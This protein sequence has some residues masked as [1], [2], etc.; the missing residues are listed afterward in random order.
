MRNILSTLLMLMMVLTEASAQDSRTYNQ[1]DENG[2]ITQRNENRNFNKNSNDTTKN[3]EVPKG[4]FAWKVDRRFGD[5]IPS[6][7][8]TIHHLFMNTTFNSGMYGEYNHTGNNYSARQS[9]IFINR[10]ENS[11]FIL[12]DPYSFFW[13]DPD[14]FVFINTLSPYTLVTYDNCGDKQ[15]GEDRI[16]GKFA[17]NVNKELGFGFDLNYDYARGYYSNQGQAH[18]D[19]SFFATY[20]GD[21]YQMHALVSLRHMKSAENGGI[22][23]DIYVTHPESLTD[24][25]DTNEFPTV[26]S[27]NWNNS[28][29][30]HLYLSHRYNVGFYRKVPMT[31]EEIKAKKFAEESKKEKEAEKEK[32]NQPEGRPK[33]A[34][35][36]GRPKDA[37]IMGKEPGK[38]DSPEIAADTTRI[39]VEGHAAIDS[40]N[41]AQ[42]IQDSIDATM[43]K[44][45]VPVTSF[46]HTLELHNYNRVYRGYKT[47]N[48]YYLDQYY[49]KGL[50]FGGD[51]IHDK[52]KH[53]QVKNT[54]AVALLEGFNKYVKAGLKAFVTN[55]FRQYKMPGLVGDTVYQQSWT[56][57][58]VSIGAQLNKTQGKTLHFNATAETWL[59]GEDAGQLKLDFSTDLNFALLGDTMRL[60]AKAMMHR[61]NPVFYQRHYHSKNLWWDNDDMSKET[62]T[63]LEGLFSYDK[64]NTKIRVAVD[65]ISNYTYYGMSYDATTSGRTK[66]TAGVFQES[67]AV[68]VMTAQLFQNFRLGPLNWENIVTYQ[69][70][71][72]NSVLPLPTWNLFTNLYLKFRIAKVLDVELGADASWFTEYEAPDFCPQL[73]QFA[74]QKNESS[75]VTLGEYPFVDVYA[76]MKLKGVR[77]FVTMCNVVNAGANHMSFLSPHYPVNG[78]VMHMGVSWPFFN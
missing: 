71:S 29:N 4:H 67:D 17:I 8:D 6:D 11:S 59:I 64:T 48:N 65:N 10:K 73:N 72:N 21:R 51:T 23:N 70:S 56:E 2:N 32:K 15:F 28:D 45:Y 13:K 34:A 43:K 3:K 12:T 52:T 22:T 25:Y 1:I 30:Q 33:D 63:R 78:M 14:E 60:K 42:A 62:H 69:N 19:A 40:L 61:L 75:R 54:F 57:N 46:I 9:R 66:M 58:N 31:P 41:R 47:P 76:N 53:L 68:R 37:V 20:I 26:L 74:V 24:S 39:K 44:E 27:D 36:M 38:K 50:E 5:V 55:D 7:R 35:P 18:F 16:D 49:T 77:F